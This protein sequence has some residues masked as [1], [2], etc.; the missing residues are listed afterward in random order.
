[1]KSVVAPYAT[2]ALCLRIVCT[3]GT[4]IR[5]TRFPYDLTMSNATVYQTGSGFD[6]SSFSAESSF[7]ASV[8]DLEGFVGYAGITRD[9]IASGVFDNARAYLFACD[10]LNPVEDYE[11]V[12]A[13]ILGKTTINDDRYKIEE[14]AMIDLIGQTVGWSHSAQCPNAFGGQEYGG[15]GIALGP[16]TVIGAVTSVGSA[17]SFTDSSRL[18]AAD[19]FGWGE[20]AFTSGQN[21][22]LAPIKVRDY[23]AGVFTLYD[24][25][26]YALTPGTTYTATPGCRK[27]LAD[28]Q[29]HGN[30]ARFGGDPY[31][32]LGS[33]VKT[34]G[35]L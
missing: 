25:P 29:R 12:V 31:V 35:G 34:T 30:V 20:V 28:C 19:Y 4:T 10:F 21:A 11:E 3:G 16:I 5:L 23:S 26:Y 9:M 7:A 17:L 24:A 6:F 15:C 18:E 32:P 2:R 13:S 14:M 27:R 8:V 33:T 22:G 1:M